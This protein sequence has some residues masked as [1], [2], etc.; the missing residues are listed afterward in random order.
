MP[1][2]CGQALL[3][4]G[5]LAGDIQCLAASVQISVMT[6]LVAACQDGGHRLRVMIG[7]VTRQVEGRPD[8]QFRQQVQ[9]SLQS[10]GGTESALRQQ[11]QP[12]AVFG[13]LPQP[14]CLAVNIEGQGNGHLGVAGPG[15]ENCSR[16]HATILR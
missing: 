1:A 5:A 11:R 10:A 6:D 15:R 7:G 8:G 12:P 3:Q 16:M 4:F 2:Q 14:W 13:S 9:D